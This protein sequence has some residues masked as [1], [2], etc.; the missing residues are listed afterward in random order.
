MSA[1]CQVTG[2]SPSFGKNVS[3]SHVR[4]SRRWNPNI[5]RRR[6][7]V[8]SLGRVVRLQVSAKGLGVIDR[9]GIDAVVAQIL[10]RGDK[11]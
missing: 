5:Q 1:H 8:P 6:F 4:A 10:A 11:L 7:Y 2:R 3:H 9:L